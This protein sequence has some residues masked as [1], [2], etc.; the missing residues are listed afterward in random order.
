MA[1]LRVRLP[2][3]L[4][5]TNKGHCVAQQ[6]GQENPENSKVSLLC[7]YVLLHTWIRFMSYVISVPLTA[8]SSAKPTLQLIPP[9]SVLFEG[10]NLQKKDSLY[11]RNPHRVVLITREHVDSK[12]QTWLL[13]LKIY[14][15]GFT[16]R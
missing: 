11:I 16:Q 3:Q 2:L 15:Q 8:S 10:L 14:N 5:E 12:I 1:T 7:N 13:L 6:R 9:A 4:Q